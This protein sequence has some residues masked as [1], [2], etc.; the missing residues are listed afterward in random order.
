M[1]QNLV[2]DAQLNKDSYNSNNTIGGVSNL[3]GWVRFAVTEYKPPAGTNFAAQLYQGPDGSY[4]ISY[5]GTAD[6][7]GAGDVAMNKAIVAGQWAA[8]MTESVRF[9]FQAIKVKL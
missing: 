4:K 2:L 8:E 9:T 3:N 5:R 1:P 6:P 7:L